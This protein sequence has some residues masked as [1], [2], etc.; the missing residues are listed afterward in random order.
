VLKG[1]AEGFVRQRGDRTGK[2]RATIESKERSDKVALRR[3]KTND[4]LAL[5]LIANALQNSG[6]VLLVSRCRQLG[7]QALACYR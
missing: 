1:R 3:L 4:A 6:L 7:L 5:A 2:D